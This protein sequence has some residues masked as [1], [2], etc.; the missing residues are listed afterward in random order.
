MP[1]VQ[2]LRLYRLQRLL[3]RYR[4]H[5]DPAA[6]ERAAP[7]DD[8][9]LADFAHLYFG[10]RVATA[11]IEP[12]LAER[13]PVDAH[14]TS[15]AA[16]L[17]RWAAERDAVTGSFAAPIATLADAL[18]SRVALRT[19]VAASQLEPA[20]PGRL[21]VAASGASWDAD[22]VVLAVPAPEALRVAE[23]VLVAAERTILAGVRYDAAITWSAPLRP[24]VRGAPARVR[25]SPRGAQPF[26]SIAVEGGRV[27]AIAGDPWASA[28]LAMSDDALEKECALAVDR[29]LPGLADGAGAVTRFP[30]AWPRFDV[31]RYRALAR[32]RAVEADRRAAG[33]PLHFAGDWL[34]AP[35]LDGA[36]AS[37]RSL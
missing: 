12:W 3:R 20:A 9:S 6:P 22:A 34:A 13:A 7:L 11:W 23:P 5:L 15:R 2:A 8:R 19:G 26:A 28:R 36:V 35:T 33:R 16:F 21:R 1:F 4:A 25:V 24:G 10:A 27:T 32:L 14:E 17:L 29:L 18:A 30:L 37:V 31:G